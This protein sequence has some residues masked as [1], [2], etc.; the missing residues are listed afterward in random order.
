MRPDRVR[1]KAWR[2]CLILRPLCLIRCTVANTDHS[3]DRALNPPQ[4]HPV[5]EYRMASAPCLA[6]FQSAPAAPASSVFA[7]AT[8]TPTSPA[9]PSARPGSPG[10]AGGLLSCSRLVPPSHTGMVV[11]DVNTVD[12]RVSVSGRLPRSS[13]L[14]RHPPLQLTD[15]LTTI[16]P[17]RAYGR[18]RSLD[19][20][21]QPA[22]T[23]GSGRP[24]LR[25]SSL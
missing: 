1:A 24:P 19:S 11:E 21:S 18:C 2:Y 20:R 16:K 7:P 5:S 17:L 9:R 12:G 14:G 15:R 13:A 6:P 25:A 22:Q 8:C 10:S 3:G 4:P 23:P